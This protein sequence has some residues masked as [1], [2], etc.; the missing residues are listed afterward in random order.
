MRR[1]HESEALPHLRQVDKVARLGESQG[2]TLQATDQ[3]AVPVDKRMSV[4]E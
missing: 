4:Y 3:S 2:G 1:S